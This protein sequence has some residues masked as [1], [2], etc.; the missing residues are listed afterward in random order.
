MLQSCG[1]KLASCLAVKPEEIRIKDVTKEKYAIRVMQ[2]SL[3]G[4]EVLVE[5]G[6]T[7]V[8]DGLE[9]TVRVKPYSK[10][11]DVLTNIT[12]IIWA[13][14]TIPAFFLVVPFVRFIILSFIVAVLLLAPLAFAIRAFIWLVMSIAYNLFGNEFDPARRAGLLDALKQVRPPDPL[15]ALRAATSAKPSPSR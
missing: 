4:M 3:S 11:E 6:F 5:K 15:A 10:I 1:K 8:S 7:L 12:T 14:L 2:G 9:V 13:L